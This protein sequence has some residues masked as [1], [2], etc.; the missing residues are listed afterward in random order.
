MEVMDHHTT[1]VGGL[2]EVIVMVKGKGAYSRL[3]F[4]SGTHRV[5]RVPTTETQGRIHTSAVTVAVLPEAEDVEVDID[6]NELRIDVFR[7]AGRAGN[8][9]TQQTRLFGLPIC[10]PDW[11]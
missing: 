1:G 9:S 6:P 5:Q 10:P 11:W 7:S 8:R 4:E 2:K 3:K